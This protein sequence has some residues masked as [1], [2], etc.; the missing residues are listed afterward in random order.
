M[1]RYSAALLFMLALVPGQLIAFA[2]ARA[3]EYENLPGAFQKIPE[4][5]SAPQ[6]EFVD[7]SGKPLDLRN[8]RGKVIVLNLWATWCG[9]CV[10]EMPSLEQLALKLPNEKF[11][12]L[13]VSQDRGGAAVAK[14]FADRLRLKELKIFFDPL[15]RLKR[16]FGVVGLPTTFLIDEEGYVR[17]QLQGPAEW[18][19]PAMADAL[20]KFAR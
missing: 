15:N 3:G 9:P 5:S 16:A 14:P 12:V 20:G 7:A 11:V 13:A 17:A 18:G 6:V 4:G 19:E 10:R 8:W 2:H 1:I